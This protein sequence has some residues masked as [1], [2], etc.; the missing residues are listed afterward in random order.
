MCILLLLLLLHEGSVAV[1]QL[2]AGHTNGHSKS[3]DEAS[4]IE[5]KAA[6]VVMARTTPLHPVQS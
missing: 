3:A 1:A 5:H 6:A 4:M 2:P